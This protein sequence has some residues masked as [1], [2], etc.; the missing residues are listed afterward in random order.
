MKRFDSG[1]SLIELLIA[2]TIMV[3]I[4]LIGV[5]SYKS[6]I[7][8]NNIAAE[9]N[10]LVGDLQY[11]RSEAVKQGLQ[12]EVCAADTS[13]AGPYACSNLPAWSAGWITLAVASNT[14]LRVQKPLTSTDTLASNSATALS[15]VSFN[16]FGFSTIRGSISV[17][18]QGGSAPAKTVCISVVGNLQLVEGGDSLCP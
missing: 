18:P 8:A 7:A 2:V 14:V 11:A 3:I 4:M 10:T 6:L 9:I 5:P 16:Y 1:F 17:T 12:V 13:G 15:A